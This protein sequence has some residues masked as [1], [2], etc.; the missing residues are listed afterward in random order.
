MPEHGVQTGRPMDAAHRLRRDV[1][2]SKS[3]DRVTGHLS[4]TGARGKYLLRLLCQKTGRRSCRITPLFGARQ[5]GAERGG[6]LRLVAAGYLAAR[7]DVLRWSRRQSLRHRGDRRQS[8]CPDAVVDDDPVETDFGA[9]EGLTRGVLRTIPSCTGCR[10][11]ASPG[12]S[13]TTCCGGFGGDD[14]ITL[15]TKARRSW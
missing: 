12:G 7:R 9:W 6:A 4:A 15:A 5:P 2:P 11:P 8:L 10:T 13:W 3:R 1:T 14:V